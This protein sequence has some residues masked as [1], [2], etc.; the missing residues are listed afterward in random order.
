MS[1][2]LYHLL[3]TFLLT[4]RQEAFAFRSTSTS[5]ST[6]S[7][8][9]TAKGDFE[10]KVWRPTKDD[11]ERISYGKKARV[12]GTGSRKVPHRLNGEE[13]SAFARAKTKGFVECFGR[14]YRRERAGSPLVNSWRN[15]SDASG[16]PAIAVYKA[17][18][19]AKGEDNDEVEVDFSTLREGG[20]ELRK[21]MV[22]AEE[23]M[24]GGVVERGEMF[25]L[26]DWS[27]IRKD[28]THQLPRCTV[29]WTCK[30]RSE[31]KALAKL[32]VKKFVE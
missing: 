11:V 13:R 9:T 21:R 12:R 18:R 7:L 28:P 16:R 4:A 32:L 2:I 25:M 14:G 26:E 10:S 24:P 20:G 5:T 3:V 1:L 17:S 6:S 23:I 15:W 30:D 31:A 27:S 22:E 29:S 19:R 8:Q